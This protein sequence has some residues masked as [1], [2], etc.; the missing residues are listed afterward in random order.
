MADAY[1]VVTEDSTSGKLVDNTSLTVGANT[2]Y[3][4]RVQVA[5]S[6]AAAFVEV[7]P[8]NP[9]SSDY[10]IVV[11]SIPQRGATGAVTAVTASTSS[12]TLLAANAA[13]LTA[14]LYSAS[15]GT[16]YVSLASASATSAFTFPMSNGSFYELPAGLYTGVITGM[17]PVAS[18]LVMVTE[19]TT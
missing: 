11:R 18:G 6:S 5:G 13:R 2:V 7:L 8:S 10:A 15:T 4:Q 1:I 14:K 16:L 17:W 19:V 12:K 9:A 3:R